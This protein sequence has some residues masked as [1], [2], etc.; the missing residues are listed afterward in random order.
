M[1]INIPF[2]AKHWDYIFLLFVALVICLQC[3]ISLTYDQLGSAP[4]DFYDPQKEMFQL[5]DVKMNILF[6]L[7]VQKA[8]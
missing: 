6:I 7:Y 2:G 4:S 1:N 8:V 3:I 5:M